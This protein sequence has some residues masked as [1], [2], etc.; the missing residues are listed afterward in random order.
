MAARYSRRRHETA[1]NELFSVSPLLFFASLQGSVIISEALIGSRAR[2]LEDSS[3][4]GRE[5]LHLVHRAKGTFLHLCREALIRGATSPR[6]AG[7]GPQ[8]RTRGVSEPTEDENPLAALKYLL[9]QAACGDVRIRANR[10]C[11]N[12]QTHINIFLTAVIKNP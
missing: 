4:D 11:I 10:S 12:I 2:P 3:V 1:L 5:F 7:A 6:G 8:R 9:F